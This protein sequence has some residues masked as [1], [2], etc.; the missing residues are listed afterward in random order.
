MSGEVFQIVQEI[1]CE[2]AELQLVLQCAP[3]LSGLKISNLLIIEKKQFK[4]LVHTLNTTDISIFFLA[5]QSN[6]IYFL[7]YKENELQEYLRQKEVHQI[8]NQNGYGT[9]DI[10]SA[11]YRL[12]KRYCCYMQKRG[13][14]PHEI[15]VFLGYPLEDVVGFIENHGKNDLYTGYWKVYENVAEKT[16]LFDKFDIVREL[17]VLLIYHG[18]GI[19]DIIE[20]FKR[21]S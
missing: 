20:L 12:S 8:L 18:A 21:S 10:E 2:K 15:G 13:N 4:K 16:K 7:A 5:H 3:L 1:D 11:L 19:L 6:K 14:F 9:I 17:M